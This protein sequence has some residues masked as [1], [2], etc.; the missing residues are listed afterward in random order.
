MTLFASLAQ[1]VGGWSINPDVVIGALLSAVL[2]GLVTIV[3][4]MF[5]QRDRLVRVLQ[6]LYGDEK[7][8]GLVKDVEEVKDD[9]AVIRTDMALMKQSMANMDQRHDEMAKNLGAILRGEVPFVPRQRRQ[10]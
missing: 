9:A 3:R 10:P 2:G 6:T 4:M 5:T 7:T 8:P 1:T